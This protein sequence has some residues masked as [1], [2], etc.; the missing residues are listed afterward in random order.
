LQEQVVAKISSTLWILMGAVGFVLLIA[1]VNVANLM[2]ARSTDRRK[3]MAIRV[4]LGAGRA[5]VVKQLLT[6]SL[7]LG[8]VGA[9]AGALLAV[10]AVKLFSISGIESLPRA[11]EVTVDRRVLLFTL[12][13]AI[14]TSVAFGLVPA[15]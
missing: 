13:T 4:A 9:S 6:E 7:L 1:C 2:L 8:C 10:W 12:I 14:V 3:E 11:E 15:L 5:R